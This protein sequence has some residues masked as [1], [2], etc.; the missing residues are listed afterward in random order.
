VQSKEPSHDEARWL[1]LQFVEPATGAAVPAHAV[2]VNEVLGLRVSVGP[3]LAGALTGDEEFPAQLLPEADLTLEVVVSSTDFA[4]G[5]GLNPGECS[6]TRGE[7]ILRAT[8]RTSGEFVVTLT[9]P[10][11]PEPPRNPPFLTVTEPASE[12]LS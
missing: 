2:Q 5:Y 11:E 7:V 9:A 6:V 1:R 4:L 12:V 3:E 8:D 10:A